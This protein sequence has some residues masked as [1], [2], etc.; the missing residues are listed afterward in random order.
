MPGFRLVSYGGNLGRD[1]SFCQTTVEDMNRFKIGLCLESLGLPLR[2]ALAEAA[3]IGV[4]GVQIEAVGDLS[5]RALS[6]SGRREFRNILRSHNLELTALGCPLRR[7]LDSAEDQQPR[8]EHVRA[9]MSLAYDL[10]PG[11]VVIQ[12]GP[13]PGEK[14]IEKARL[15]GEALGDL[16]RHGD[17]IGARLAIETGLDPGAD[18]AAYLKSFA[19]GG[20]AVN[21]DPAN[22]L[23]HGFDPY[24]STRD[25]AGLICHVH[26]K[27]GRRATTSQVAREVPLGHGDIDWLAF[28]ETLAEIEFRG[29]LTVERETGLDRVADVANGVAFLKRLTG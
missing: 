13:L 12:A 5:P 9:V 20:L 18:L 3:R 22:L 11:I 28:L 29:W 17:R 24:Q 7:G 19:L 23:L 25:L 21:L 4:A 10:G 14:E 16:G 2:K 1:P 27:D 26:A 6:Q 8:L 15:L